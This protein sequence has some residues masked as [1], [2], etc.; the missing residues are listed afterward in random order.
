MVNIYNFVR[1][2]LELVRCLDD[3]PSILE[4]LISLEVFIT[5]CL[6]DKSRNENYRTEDNF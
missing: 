6:G 2:D 3:R 5:S 4:H 1:S